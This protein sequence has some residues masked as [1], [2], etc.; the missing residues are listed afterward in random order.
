MWRGVVSGADHVE[1]GLAA[2]RGGV[3]GEQG[4]EVAQ[5]GDDACANGILDHLSSAGAG[6]GEGRSENVTSVYM[7]VSARGVAERTWRENGCATANIVPPLNPAE[8]C[9]GANTD[10]PSMI[11]NERTS[12]CYASKSQPH[13]ADLIE[14][15]DEAFVAF[16]LL[17]QF[18]A[19]LALELLGRDLAPIGDRTALACSA[20]ASPGG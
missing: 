15:R 7:Y 19:R 5:G 18:L 10:P 16:L 8:A 20:A 3:S 9:L 14:Q 17:G 12:A 1:E 13:H 2:Q 4:L 6:E 11:S